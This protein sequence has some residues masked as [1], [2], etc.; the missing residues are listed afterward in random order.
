M[1]SVN[2]KIKRLLICGL[3]AFYLPVLIVLVGLPA[4]R[5]PFAIF[6]LLLFAFSLAL[7]QLLNKAGLL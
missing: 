7:E 5:Y 1:K 6:A 3:I 2:D 4:I